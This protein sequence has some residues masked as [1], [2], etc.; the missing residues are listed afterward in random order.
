MSY[1]NYG[2]L[3]CTIDKARPLTGIVAFRLVIH[4]LVPYATK[5]NRYVCV[6]SFGLRLFLGIMTRTVPIRHFTGTAHILMNGYE[7]LSILLCNTL[8]T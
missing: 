3:I 5:Q 7:I 6:E 2:H 1:Q 4:E 8:P